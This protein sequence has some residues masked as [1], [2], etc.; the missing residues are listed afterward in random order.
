[1][2]CGGCS[3]KVEATLKVRFSPACVQY[4]QLSVVLRTFCRVNAVWTVG[5]NPS[6]SVPTVA[7]TSNMTGLLCACNVQ[8]MDHVKGVQVDLDTKLATVEVEAPNLIDAMN[9]LPLFVKAIKVWESAYGVITQG[10][11][12]LP[13]L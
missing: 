6:A 13:V 12:G 9:M 5:C 8:A 11:W 1:M 10:L 2:K 3:S 7:S 4:W